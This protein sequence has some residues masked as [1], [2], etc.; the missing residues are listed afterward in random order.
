[1]HEVTTKVKRRKKLI[2]PPQLGCYFH[3]QCFPVKVQRKKSGK[4]VSFPIECIEAF[5]PV[6]AS[7]MEEQVH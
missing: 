7:K 3:L 1:M 6:V 4:F 2:V 5:A